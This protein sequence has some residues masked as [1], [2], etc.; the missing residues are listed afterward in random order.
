MNPNLIEYILKN[1]GL[2]SM[3]KGSIITCGCLLVVIF[4]GIFIVKIN[5][6]YR[7]LDRHTY[8]P[9]IQ[10]GGA[11][12]SIAC[13]VRDIPDPMAVSF[14]CGDIIVSGNFRWTTRC[15][16]KADKFQ[17]IGKEVYCWNHRCVYVGPGEAQY[18]RGLML[19]FEFGVAE[20]GPPLNISSPRYRVTEQ[21]ARDTILVHQV[22]CS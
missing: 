11:P 6:E 21:Q 12:Y 17:V 19:D 22:M 13:A 16:R 7:S 9:V 14:S 8:I 20:P 10:P 3:I 1:P 18:P 4:V 5:N 15:K 2:I